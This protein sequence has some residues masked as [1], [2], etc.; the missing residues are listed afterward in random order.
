MSTETVSERLQWVLLDLGMT[1]SEFAAALGHPIQKQHVDAWV[2]KG[3]SP[4]TDTLLLIE[5]KLGYRLRW[6]KTGR[7]PRRVGDDGA[8]DLDRSAVDTVAILDRARLELI[9]AAA[10]APPEALD[11]ARAVF[12]L[13]PMDLSVKRGPI[14][15]L[16]RQVPP[17]RSDDTKRNNEN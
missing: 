17:A 4:S 7:G 16:E 1:K 11:R 15:P 6:I 14:A 3:S 10:D 5:D 9:R 13:P 8:A 12:G 2:N